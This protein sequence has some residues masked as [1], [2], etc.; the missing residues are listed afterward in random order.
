VQRLRA[1]IRSFFGFSRTETNAF[2]ILIPLLAAIIFSEPLYEVWFVRQPVD[3]SKEYQRLDSLI[4]T[5][6]WDVEDSVK[7]KPE[8]IFF[9]FNPNTASKAELISLGF[10]EPL[11]NR[12]VN[13]RS[14]KGVFR[15]KQDLLKMF[16]MDS[17]HYRQLENYILI[18]EPKRDSIV[19]FSKA[20]IKPKEKSDINLADSTALTKVFGIGAKLSVRI[21]KYRNNLGGFISTDQLS[22]VYGLDSAVVNRIKEKFQVA[23][24]FIPAKININTA[25]E[26]ELGVHPYIGY[27][28]AKALSTYRFQHGAFKNEEDLRQIKLID[29]KALS[30]MKPYLTY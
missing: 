23:T 26:K 14:K 25:S 21:L 7:I 9:Q 3:H 16:G 2:L 28:L 18:P 5:W 10:N 19:K 24:D 29:E 12:I 17:A 22:E 15:K 20:E 30:K 1:W 27:K 4:S 11:A 13:Y 6:Q 8:R